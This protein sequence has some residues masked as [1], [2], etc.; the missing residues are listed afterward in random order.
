MMFCQKFG[1]NGLNPL[2]MPKRVLHRQLS[3]VSNALRSFKLKERYEVLFFLLEF[4]L[5][6]RLFS[7]NSQLH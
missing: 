4:Q 3:L 5:F 6:V 7:C 1:F 2:R